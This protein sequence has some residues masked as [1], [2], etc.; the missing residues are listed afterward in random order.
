MG[1]H[2]VKKLSKAEDR[3]IYSRQLLN[4]VAAL[5]Q[6]LDQGLFE[7]QPLRIGAEQ[8]FCLVDKDWYPAPKA[9]EILERLKDDHFTTEIALYNLEVNL[10]PLILEGRCFSKLH[11]EVISMISKVNDAAKVF[12][13][14][15]LLT[16]IL[17]TIMPKHLKENFMTPAERYFALN[18]T[19]RSL[20]GRNF[21]LHIKGIDEV[22]LMHD[23]VLFEGCN[24]SFQ[25]HLQI[26]PYDFVKSFNWSQAI[27]GP[28]LSICANS[29]ILQGKELWDETRIAL[30]AQSIDTR[31]SSY[32]LNEREARVSFGQSW[33]TGTAVDIFKENIVRFR[34]VITTDFEKDSLQEL[35]NGTIPKLR[36]L[37]L[38]NGTVYRWNR[39]CYGITDGKPHLRIECR[40]IPA[41]PSIVDEIANMVFW[42]G[43]MSGRPAKFDEVD[44]KMDFKDVKSNFFNA[45]RYGM[46]SQMYWE[47]KL[48]PVDQLILGELIP[49]AAKGLKKVDIDP[50]DIEYYLNI[51]RDRVKGQNGSRWCRLSYRKLN[52]KYKKIDASRAL[53]AAIY[54]NQKEERPISSWEVIDEDIEIT[55]ER[56][57][58]V[59]QLMNRSVI[60]A[61]ENDSAEFVAAIMEWKNIHH[62][63]IIDDAGKL[64][65][66]VTTTDI[67]GMK[68]AG[69]TAAVSEF[70]K[71]DIVVVNPE[72]EI[73]QAKDI[74]ENAQIGCLPII[75]YGSLVGI[76]TRSDF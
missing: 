9:L 57:K 72:T 21:D 73:A 17:P 15:P 34:S 54:K 39:P 70:M 41:G 59:N 55:A 25:A 62:M 74:M 49:M 11:K 40:Y 76:I 32:Q 66:L 43:L 51:I 16:G 14:K 67:E 44:K 46:A 8:E 4:D 33:A 27:A 45:A 35:S 60:T 69:K 22:S 56:Y 19:M 30:F 47:G 29:P 36:A 48:I 52:V 20:R 10:E 58:K 50:K 2:L 12:K 18:E 1:E 3:A 28:V 61:N 5:G 53:V 38:H 26:D 64:K 75:N 71:T 37:N 63:P 31:A 23:S 68:S 65:G 7:R 42:I 6:M 24:T 13:T